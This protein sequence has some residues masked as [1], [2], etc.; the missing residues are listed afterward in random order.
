MKKIIDK[1][2]MGI[3]VFLC[4]YAFLLVSSNLPKLLNELF[5]TTM[6]DNTHTICFFLLCVLLFYVYN[7]YEHKISNSE[8]TNSLKTL[9][10]L[11]GL[12]YFYTI[13]YKLLPIITKVELENVFTAKFTLINSI[14]VSIDLTLLTHLDTTDSIVKF[15]E[16]LTNS[17]LGLDLS[18]DVFLN[19]C[20]VEKSIKKYFNSKE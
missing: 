5:N 6:F 18:K 7:Y 9:K 19:N 12:N 17:L 1:I 20:I 2:L 16:F 3:F 10:Q 11:E 14:V 15:N 13:N 4:L 8:H